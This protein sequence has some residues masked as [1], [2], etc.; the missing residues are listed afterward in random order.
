M[1]LRVNDKA[2]SSTVKIC[3]LEPI[4]AESMVPATAKTPLVT[5][6]LIGAI[7]KQG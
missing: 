1:Y 7:E 2:G 5:V 6:V 4:A 3:K